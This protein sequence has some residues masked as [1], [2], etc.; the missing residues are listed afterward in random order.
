MMFFSG[1]VVKRLLALPLFNNDTNEYFGA[2]H[3]LNK[4]QGRPNDAFTEVDEL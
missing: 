2:I 3:I 4:S 1:V